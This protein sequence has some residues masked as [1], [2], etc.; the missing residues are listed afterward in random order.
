MARRNFSHLFTNSVL[1]A[2]TLVTLLVTSGCAKK[3]KTM[4]E[5]SF[6]ELRSKAE[7]SAATKKEDTAIECL[8]H[9]VAQFPDNA[10]IAQYKLQL[11][12]LLLKTGN[13]DASYRVY[14]QYRTLYPADEHAE[15]AHY[16]SILAKFYQ[17]LKMSKDC[18]TTETEKAIK[19]CTKYLDNNSN[20]NYRT[21]V[22][23]ILTTCESRLIDKE[24]YIFST[25]LRQG[26]FQS[27]ENRIKYLK[28]NFLAKNQALEPRILYLEYKLAHEQKNQEAAHKKIDALLEKY[29]ES[30][31]TR[32]AAGIAHKQQTSGFEF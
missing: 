9:M 13:L 28:E 19:L 24:A 2:G 8:K 20:K 4:D 12:D 31:F 32:M 5:M 16:Q 6:D 17:T 30:Q 26:K 7:L 21:D 23:D 25:Y 1:M 14:K 3:Y 18:D 10:N 15:Y 11:A 22:K 29:P 27:A